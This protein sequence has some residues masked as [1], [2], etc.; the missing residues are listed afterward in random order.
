M[1]IQL[2]LFNGRC[3]EAF[4]FYQ[5]ALGAEVTALMRFK[6][7]PEPEPPEMLPP[8]FENKVMHGA[9]PIGSTTLLA[10]DGQCDGKPSFGGFSLTLSV[11]TD[12]DAEGVFAALSDGGTVEMP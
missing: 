5:R 8:G 11:A 12:A 3:E 4:A 1:H 9:L 10:A 7:S 6:E 2:Y